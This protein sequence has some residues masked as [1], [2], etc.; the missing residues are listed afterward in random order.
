MTSDYHKNDPWK[1]I[2]G[3]VVGSHAYGLNTENSDVDRMFFAAAPTVQFHGLNP[4]WGKKGTIV[5][6]EPEDVVTHEVAKAVSLM[7]KCNPSVLELLWLDEYE[8]R[9]GMGQRLIELRSH[10]LS[11]SYVRNAYFGYATD[12]FTRLK[13]ELRFPDVPVKRSRKHARHMLR[14]LEQ[15]TQLYS[16]GTFEVKLKD[17]QRYFDLADAIV[18]DPQVGVDEIRRAEELFDTV[19]T[20]LPKDPNLFQIEVWLHA[21]RAGN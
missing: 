2:L 19:T 12:Q 17:P 14:L 6:H 16:T 20:P 9:T 18:N 3:G 15:G 8:V 13:N 11:K 4:P 1:P 21:V 5:Q 7:L 10:F